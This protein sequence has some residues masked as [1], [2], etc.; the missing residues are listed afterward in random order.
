MQNVI[1]QFA[2]LG[3]DSR[4]SFFGNVTVGQ[5]VPLSLLRSEFDGVGAF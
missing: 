2:Q 4:V 3:G 1:N 5:D